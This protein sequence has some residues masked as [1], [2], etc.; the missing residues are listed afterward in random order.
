[1]S[2]PAF[3]SPWA[4]IIGI[5]KYVS[6]N[7]LQLRGAVADAR[8]VK[9][10]LIDDLGVPGDNIKTLIDEEATRADIIK[11]IR[12]L[13]EHPSIHRN[14]PILIFFAGH[15]G[16][17]PAPEGWPARRSKVQYIVP[18]DY[19][20]EREGEKVHGIPDLSIAELLNE[21]AITK[22][23]NIVVI[24]DCCHSGSGTRDEFRSTEVPKGFEF[25]G[26]GSHVLLAAC[27]PEQSAREIGDRGAFTQEL[28]RTIKALGTQNLT[29]DL[30]IKRLS[31]LPSQ[32]P[33]CEGKNRDRYVFRTVT[34]PK[35][36]PFYQVTK[37]DGSYILEAG[38]VHGI[39]A[40]CEFSL[41]KTASKDG[42]CMGKARVHCVDALS[43]VVKIIE[44]PSGDIQP[45]LFAV[46]TLFGPEN[47]LHVYID[48]DPRL[49]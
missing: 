31:P 41:Y 6:P 2:S 3:K 13:I 34:P 17:G 30:L 26:D 46:Q 23:D 12:W 49:E 28:L 27:A 21:L 15:G 35:Q 14:D 37:R 43:S 32:N 4:L 36:E 39:T 20:T 44:H 18:H 7:V 5:N 25:H 45:P 48:D 24:F 22:G 33:L 8:A 47:A 40:G 9:D 11:G 38:E 16:E 42:D 1:M 29:Y 10:Y 19:L